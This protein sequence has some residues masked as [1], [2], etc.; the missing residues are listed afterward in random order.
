[1]IACLKRPLHSQCVS[2][3]KDH[4]YRVVFL[5]YWLS[6]YFSTI[7]LSKLNDLFSFFLFFFFYEILILGIILG[8]KRT[9]IVHYIYTL[10]CNSKAETLSYSKTIHKVRIEPAPKNPLSHSPKDISD[11]IS[12]NRTDTDPIWMDSNRIIY[13]KKLNI[14]KQLINIKIQLN[15]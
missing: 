4:I 15:L 1:M 6:L 13:I 10:R 14:L 5:F 12:N 2:T 11:I 7:L 8:W 3:I 9:T